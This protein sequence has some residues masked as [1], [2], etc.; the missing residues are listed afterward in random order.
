[1]Q[2]P[3]NR[4]RKGDRVQKIDNDKVQKNDGMDEKKRN[5]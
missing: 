4:E 2:S 1:M 5:V 3:D